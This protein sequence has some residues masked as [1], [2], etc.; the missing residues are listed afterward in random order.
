MDTMTAVFLSALFLSSP[1]WLAVIIGKLKSR[2]EA[3]ENHRLNAIETAMRMGYDWGYEE[4]HLD[5]WRENDPNFVPKESPFSYWNIGYN[6]PQSKG[7]EK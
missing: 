5:A 3:K 7:S 1:L 2:R 4:G 6:Y